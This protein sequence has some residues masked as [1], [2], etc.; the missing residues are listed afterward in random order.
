MEFSVWSWTSWT[1]SRNSLP[2]TKNKRALSLET[3]LFCSH[4]QHAG[5]VLRLLNPE[6]AL[7][8]SKSP[9][10]PPVRL[11]CGFFLLLASVCLVWSRLVVFSL[12]WMTE[13]NRNTWGFFCCREC[14][15]LVAS[16]LLSKCGIYLLLKLGMWHDWKPQTKQL[17]AKLKSPCFIPQD[18]GKT[19]QLEN[20]TTWHILHV[21]LSSSA[22]IQQILKLQHLEFLIVIN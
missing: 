9:F 20:I 21:Y 12:R 11:C 22:L 2:G 4:K 8:N 5:W 14:Q 1:R 3:L 7:S 13:M 16:A 18:L 19:V 17:E 15:L 10:K 6:W